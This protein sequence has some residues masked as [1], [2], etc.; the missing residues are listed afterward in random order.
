MNIEY[1]VKG[2]WGKIDSFLEK[3]RN[4]VRLGLLD[5]YGRRGVKYLSDA[6]PKDT[7]LAASSWRYEIVRS[8]GVTSLRWCNDDIEDGY[9]VAILI[10][11]GHA[12]KSGTWVEG[13]DFVNPALK[14]LFEE[15]SIEIWEEV[16]NS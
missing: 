11:Y 13:R 12:T 16:A 6:T 1:N 9:N 8:D 2:D 15:M 14:K 7:G 10:Q 5:K 4:F 3:G